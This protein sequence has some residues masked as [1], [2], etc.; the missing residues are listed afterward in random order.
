MYIG[1]YITFQNK[2]RLYS[3]L[4]HCYQKRCINNINWS[5][6]WFSSFYLF[7]LQFV[8]TAV[9]RLLFLGRPTFNKN[10]H[11]NYSKLKFTM[12]GI[13]FSETFLN[14]LSLLWSISVDTDICQC[15]NP[16]IVTNANRNPSSGPYNCG[17]TVSY[18]CFS[19][20]T[21]QGNNQLRCNPITR[22]WDGIP[23]FCQR[24]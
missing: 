17:T 20:Y 14:F 11:L 9:H 12:D 22:Q 13:V 15:G 4:V 21:L 19:G 18:S 6:K 16:P 3:C 23:P 7:S 5:C 1:F 2:Y 24:M 10:Q 8:W